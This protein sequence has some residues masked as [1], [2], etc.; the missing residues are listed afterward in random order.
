MLAIF[1][2][3]GGKKILSIILGLGLASL[4]RQVCKGNKCLIIKGPKISDI[5]KS[6]Y[7]IDKECYKYKPYAT[8]CTE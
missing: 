1:E 3:E 2:T 8:K 5:S 4:F 6:I 7:K